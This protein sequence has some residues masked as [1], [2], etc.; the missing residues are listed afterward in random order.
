VEGGAG[1]KRILLGCGHAD[2]H[3]IGSGVPI[4]G[5]TVASRK[6]K[7]CSAL[8]RSLLHATVRLLK[9]VKNIA[10]VGFS[11]NPSR[12][13]YG[14]VAA[15]QKIGYRIVPVHPAAKEVLGAKAYPAALRRRC[16]ERPESAKKRCSPNVGN[17][18]KTGAGMQFC[19][20]VQSQVE[21]A[22]CP[23]GYRR[24]VDFMPSR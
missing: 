2:A 17:G 9:R 3:R 8:R 10:V 12:P 6:R 19:M 16:A 15:L 7:P 21:F 5:S 11:P 18:T 1:S 13:S 24:P 4:I 23:F 14:I 20:T 22:L